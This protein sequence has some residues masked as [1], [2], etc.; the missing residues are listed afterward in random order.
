MPDFFKAIGDPGL[1][2]CDRFSLVS[3][4]II[5]ADVALQCT[6]IVLNKI[7]FRF[8]YKHYLRCAQNSSCGCKHGKSLEGNVERSAE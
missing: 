1:V 4:S 8:L 2:Q 7:I 5:S 3:F 6:I